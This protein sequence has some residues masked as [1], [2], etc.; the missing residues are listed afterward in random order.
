MPSEETRNIKESTRSIKSSCSEFHLQISQSKTQQIN[1]GTWVVS[2]LL[3]Q[4]SGAEFGAEAKQT[5]PLILPGWRRVCKVRTQS[6]S[7]PLKRHIYFFRWMRNRV[8]QKTKP[9]KWWL[10]VIVY[11]ILLHHNYQEII[12][13]LYIFDVLDP[14][15]PRNSCVSRD[16]CH[17]WKDPPSLRCQ[18]VLAWPRHDARC[19]QMSTGN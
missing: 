6:A 3:P 19:I 5:S 4:T 13:M 7:P 14:H 8:E 2:S 18:F 17:P 15:L 9:C 12:I 1:E 11:G 16:T 10:M